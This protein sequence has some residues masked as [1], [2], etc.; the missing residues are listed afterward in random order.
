MDEIKKNQILFLKEIDTRINDVNKFYELKNNPSQEY[1]NI[2]TNFNEKIRSYFQS[3]LDK[4]QS[5]SDENIILNGM[6]DNCRQ[7]AD[8]YR[9]S[10]VC[11]MN[12]LYQLEETQFHIISK[13]P[14]LLTMYNDSETELSK[15]K[16]HIHPLLKENHKLRKNIKEY[17]EREESLI[18]YLLQYN[19]VP[20]LFINSIAFIDSLNKNLTKRAENNSELNAL[21]KIIDNNNEQIKK[22]TKE[23]EKTKLEKELL[24]EEKE[25]V[26][27]SFA[28]LKKEN[29]ALKKSLNDLE[30]EHKN[31]RKENDTHKDFADNIQ[32]NVEV[33]RDEKK[34]L[35][36][37]IQKL[38]EELSN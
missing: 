14:I 10:Y 11:V 18:K 23:L 22:L 27:N 5:Y 31:L 16:K 20:Y 15:L 30:I 32:A 9:N 29:L 28:E 35:N 17:Q 37:K 13:V 21:K 4:L 7:C 12:H 34:S 36:E 25:L 24:F 38:T 6:K 2:A 26:D 3:L 1:I 33:L 19:E 8:I